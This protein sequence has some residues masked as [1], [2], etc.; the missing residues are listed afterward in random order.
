MQLEKKD[1][2][3]KK[4]GAVKSKKNPQKPFTHRQGT[5]EMRQA[6]SNE[7]PLLNTLHTL[8]KKINI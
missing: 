4:R 8:K 3:K 2:A 5:P 7:K 6:L 1:A